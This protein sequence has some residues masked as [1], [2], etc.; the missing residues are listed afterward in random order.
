MNASDERSAG[1]L[2]DHV[3]RA[4]ESK[5]IQVNND[6]HDYGKPNCLILDEIDG[7]DAR[8]AIQALVE[9][10]RA[11]IPP[12]GSKGKRSPYLR[13]PIIFICNNK[14]SPVLRPL[15]QFA[16]QFH[17]EAPS[18]TR[19]VGRLKEVLGME[20]VCM[21]SGA[22]LLH[23]LVVSSGGDIRSCLF[24]LQYASTQAGDRGDISNP[25]LCALGGA[26]TKDSRADIASTLN[27]IFRK[28]KT[29]TAGRLV[30]HSDKNCLKRVFDSVERLGEDSGTMN[31]LFLNI[32]RVSYIDPTLDR[33]STAHELISAAD[34][35]NAT[36]SFSNHCDVPFVAAS[37]HLLCRVEL[38]ADLAYSTRD[39][40]DIHFQR[41]TNT[42]M[43]QRFIEGLPPKSGSM[44]SLRVLVQEL[45]P[46]ALWMLSAGSGKSSL[47]RAA[48]SI[49]MLTKTERASLDVH[50][51]LLQS[52]G[53]TYAYDS[54]E[55][56]KKRDFSANSQQQMVL[57]PPINRLVVFK[58]LRVSPY[59]RRTEIPTGVSSNF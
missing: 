38:K 53:L 40:T 20:K 13:R 2:T 55:L 29:K 49:D 45:I 27:D 6:H 10:I 30:E 41:E 43:V 16:K 48:S 52:L 42:G 33:C 1:I 34:I 59:F 28:V 7:A 3:L 51:A 35:R 47:G 24:T 5:T 22:P 39:F 36:T 25:L 58:E 17:V 4:M 56:S 21:M 8:G 14:Y 15:L 54:D 19:L 57:E 46:Y 32:P 12:K 23:Q 18:E 11:E 37:I 50:V 44:K 31:A 9:I 26:G